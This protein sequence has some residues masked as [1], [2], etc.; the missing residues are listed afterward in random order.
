LCALPAKEESRL[1]TTQGWLRVLDRYLGWI[2]ALGLPLVL[3]ISLL[4]FLQWPLRDLVQAYSRE[5]NDLGQWLFA[6]Y[7]SLAISYA[8]R[9]RSHLAADALARHYAPDLRTRLQRVAALVV[10]APWSLF[11]LYSAWPIVKQSVLQLEAFPDTYNPGYF[12]VKIAVSLLALLVF[13]QSVVDAARAP[14]SR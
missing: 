2:T 4:L 9:A 3:P 1:T 6:L 7:V 10:L 12:I 13:L 8:T 11:I 5:A 14:D